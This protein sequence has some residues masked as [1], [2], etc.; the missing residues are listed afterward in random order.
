MKWMRPL[1]LRVWDNAQRK[2]HYGGACHKVGR[3]RWFFGMPIPNP[4]DCELMQ[5]TGVTDYNGTEIYEGDVVAYFQDDIRQISHIIFAGGMFRLEHSTVDLQ[6][7]VDTNELEVIGNIHS[8][9]ELL[10]KDSP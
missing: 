4:N 1:K 5:F 8:E 3:H 6:S 7:W 10:N 2:F 9:P